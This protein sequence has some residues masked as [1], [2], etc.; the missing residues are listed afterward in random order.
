MYIIYKDIDLYFINLLL[1]HG[2]IETLIKLSCLNRKYN[3]IINDILMDMYNKF[4]EKCV[5]TGHLIIIAIKNIY[6]KYF[7]LSIE[8]G[9]MNVTKFIYYKFYRH[10]KVN[11]EIDDDR[12]P[13]QIACFDGYLHILKW[14]YSLSD[15]TELIKKNELINTGIIYD[16]IYNFSPSHI[17]EWLDTLPI[18][19]Y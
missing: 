18:F 13:F 16:K 12:W 17:K 7:M 14:M 9:N 3:I 6:A 2:E 5:E 15:K 10:I 8:Q 19:N 11:I 1:D 4:V